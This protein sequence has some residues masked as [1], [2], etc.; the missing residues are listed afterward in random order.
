MFLVHMFCENFKG[1]EQ[2]TPFVVSYPKFLSWQKKKLN[3]L[4]IKD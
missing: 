4:G 2:K 3:S 1:K